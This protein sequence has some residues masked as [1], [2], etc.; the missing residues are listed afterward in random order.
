MQQLNRGQGIPEAIARCS[1]DGTAA[2][3]AS[4]DYLIRNKLDDDKLL[5]ARATEAALG[6]GMLEL[7]SHHLE[8]ETAGAVRL[9]WL[10]R[11]TRQFQR[12]EAAVISNVQPGYF[13]SPISSQGLRVAGVFRLH[14]SP[15]LSRFRRASMGLPAGSVRG[16]FIHPHPTI[17]PAL[18]VRGLQPCFT[19][20]QPLGGDAIP[21]TPKSHQ[22]KHQN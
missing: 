16:V 22:H 7:L 9:E 20:L 18:L 21:T 3:A 15:L 17:L 2:S 11:R 10:G 4:L 13:T 8:A 19:P 1:L 14:H 6:R 12:C 5:T